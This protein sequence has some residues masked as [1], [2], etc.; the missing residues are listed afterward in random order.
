MTWLRVA[1]VQPSVIFHIIIFLIFG[2]GVCYKVVHICFPTWGFRS[3]WWFKTRGTGWWNRAIFLFIIWLVWPH[4]RFHSN[5]IGKMPVWG[6]YALV[7]AGPEKA[8]LDTHT[9]PSNAILGD[10][11]AFKHPSNLQWEK[12]MQTTYKINFLCIFLFFILS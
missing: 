9:A 10:F 2:V 3:N 6:P 12:Q 11:V 4:A 5:S 8:V 7:Q 1:V